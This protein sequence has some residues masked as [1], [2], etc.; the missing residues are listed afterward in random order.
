MHFLCI[1]LFFASYVSYCFIVSCILFLFKIKMF[2][3]D[4]KLSI[5]T[6]ITCQCIHKQH[7]YNTYK[8]FTESLSVQVYAIIL[9]F[10]KLPV[11]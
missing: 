11:T 8:M 3:F 10:F 7:C 6:L 1:L 4:Y 2:V 5:K 9:T